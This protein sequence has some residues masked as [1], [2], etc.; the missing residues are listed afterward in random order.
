MTTREPGGEGNPRT[1]GVLA[2]E[3]LKRRGVWGALRNALA[4]LENRDFRI[5]WFGVSAHSFTLWMEIVARNWLVYELTGSV[6]ALGWINFWRTIPVLFLAIPAGVIADRVNRKLIL[7]TTQVTILGVYG[8]LL[9][10]LLADAL[11]LWH[12]YALF[13]ARGVA[14][15]FNQPPRQALIPALVKPGQVP[16]AVA[17]QQFGFN[18]TRVFAPILTGGLFIVGGA[19]AAFAVIVAVEVLIVIAWLAMRV[20]PVNTSGR[21]GEPREGA[22]RS[23]VDGLQYAARHR[24]VLMLILFGLLSLLFLQPWST[25][26]PVLAAEKF[27]S[28]AGGYGSLISLSG[29]GSVIGPVAIV[30]LG[31]FRAKGAIVVGAMVLSGIT[32]MG[33]AASP[34]LLLAMGLVVAL[35]FF[36]SAQ[37]VLTN[38]LLLT[39]TDPAYHGRIVSLYLLDRGFVPIGSVI[40]GYLAEYLSPSTALLLLGGAMVITVGLLAASQPKFLSAR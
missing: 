17:I 26:L 14:I 6:V 5:L 39:Q 30:A 32:L 36:D 35:G 23:T 38:S 15:T 11:E 34:T 18:G 1:E 20:P 22:I 8:L 21:D 9:V 19:S 10:L 7:L 31:G 2:T 12:A 28:G 37:R 33:V 29:V 25:I 4:P 3:T 16:N 40:A 27:G 13:F 24:V